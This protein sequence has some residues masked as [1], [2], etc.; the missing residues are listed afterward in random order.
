MLAMEQSHAR[1]SQMQMGKFI[2]TGYLQSGWCKLLFLHRFL[3]KQGTS[4]EDI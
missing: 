3:S 2:M 4:G 1:T